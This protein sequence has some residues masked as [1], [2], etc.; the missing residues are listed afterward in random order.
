LSKDRG[1]KKVKV[2]T[3][4]FEVETNKQFELIDITEKV[5]GV[6]SES[7]LANGSAVIFSPHTTASIRINHNEPLLIQDFMKTL[8]RLSPVDINYA[9]DVFEIRENV[10]VGERSNGHAHVKAFL[11]GSSESV[12]FMDG[13]LV[14]GDRQSIFLVELDGGRKR[15]FYVQVSGE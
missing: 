1:P 8:Y 3:K 11:L 15:D 2:T 6:V 5:L 12:P 14:L 9:H 7:G 13:G 4:R 10:A